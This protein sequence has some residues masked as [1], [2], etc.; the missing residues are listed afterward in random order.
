M[1]RSFDFNLNKED[2]QAAFKAWFI[3]HAAN[4]DTFH[5]IEDFV[6]E[7]GAEA[8]SIGATEDFVKYVKQIK[9][10]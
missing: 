7:D 5:K 4:V 6:G 1:G 10:E 2:I 8:Y 3:E 9:G